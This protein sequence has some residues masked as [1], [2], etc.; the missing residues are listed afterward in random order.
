MLMNIK[1]FPMVDPKSLE[2]IINDWLIKMGDI[3]I[4]H[5]SQ[6]QVQHGQAM[7]MPITVCILYSKIPPAKGVKL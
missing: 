3:N 6:S 1:V 5:I 7:S 2:T 4:M